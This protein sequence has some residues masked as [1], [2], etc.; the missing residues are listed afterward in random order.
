MEEKLP[1]LPPVQ[2]VPFSHKAHAPLGVKC[3]DCHAIREP[4]FEAGIPG[5][6]VCMG[7][8]IAI[9]K[10]SPSIQ[11]LA[12][13]AKSKTRVPWARIY[14]VPDYVWFSHGVHVEEA[15][16]DCAVCHGAVAARDAMFKEKPTNMA[17]C[18][19]CHAERGASNG[20]DSCHSTR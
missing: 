9:R 11:K 3:R 10:E 8:H 5:E 1:G 15:K 13:F 16:V 17:S 6:A 18:M 20:C 19:A 12:G 14:A 2:P 4:G 7:C